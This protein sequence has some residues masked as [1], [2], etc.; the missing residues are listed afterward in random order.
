MHVIVP[1]PQYSL[2]GVILAVCN[3]SLSS[4][5]MVALNVN[6]TLELMTYS[7]GHVV[8]GRYKHD[9]RLHYALL[10]IA[11]D[12]R[13]DETIR[14]LC[15]A[16]ENS[17]PKPGTRLHSRPTIAL[18]LTHLIKSPGYYFHPCDLPQVPQRTHQIPLP[19]LLHQN[20]RAMSSTLS[21]TPL[22][23]FNRSLLASYS[24][25]VCSLSSSITNS[26]TRSSSPLSRFPLSSFPPAALYK[27]K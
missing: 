21:S 25:S 26:L 4:E 7:K 20:H 11:H 12:I 22:L 2:Q 16:L 13:P 1:I 5:M 18:P 10:Q 9:P 3:P 17:Q 27:L 14:C 8:I 24:P 23:L 6:V 15:S 19:V